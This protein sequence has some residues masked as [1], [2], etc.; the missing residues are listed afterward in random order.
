MLVNREGRGEPLLKKGTRLE[1]PELVLGIHNKSVGWSDPQAW[2]LAP[3]SVDQNK[4][5][6]SFLCSQRGSW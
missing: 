1:V 2:G 4:F 3:S 5:R 6:L